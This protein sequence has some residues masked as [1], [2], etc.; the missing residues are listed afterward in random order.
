VTPPELV[1]GIVTERGVLTPPFDFR[2]E[3]LINEK[4]LH[5]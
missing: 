4:S 3:L 5:C 2:S 1:T